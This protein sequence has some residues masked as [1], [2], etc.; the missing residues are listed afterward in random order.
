MTRVERGA[1]VPLF[2]LVFPA[3]NLRGGRPGP[4]YRVAVLAWLESH[5]RRIVNNGR[6]LQQEVSKIAQH[7]ALAGYGVRT[8][9]AKA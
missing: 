8:S 4:A 5:G 3:V 9:Y 1:A 2:G 7:E 6:A